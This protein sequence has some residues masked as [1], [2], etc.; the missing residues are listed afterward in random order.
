M[1]NIL[2]ANALPDFECISKL[3]HTIWHEHYIKIISL[4]QIE[5]MLDKYN[6]VKSM[7]ER[8][9]DGHLFFY[10]TYNDLPVGYLAIEK[11]TNAIYISKLYVLK[12]YRGLKIAKTALLYAISIA[13]EE[14][15]PSV[16]LHVNKYNA[17]ALLA[18]EKMGFVNT[19]SVITDIGKGF[20]MDDYLM[21]KPIK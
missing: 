19:E 21:V 3:A 6:S 12:E 13:M 15:L 4:E 9:R 2:P 18:Y 8:A 11:Q 17:M 5:Y 16:K 14:G 20:I 1:I 10:M 7:Q